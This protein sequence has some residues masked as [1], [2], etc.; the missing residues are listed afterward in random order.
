ML[1]GNGS[2]SSPSANSARSARVPEHET[3]PYP[4]PLLAR[5]VHLAPSV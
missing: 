2:A 1:E 3:L 4:G 5:G